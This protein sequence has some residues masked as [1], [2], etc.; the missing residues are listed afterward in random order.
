MKN[1]SGILVSA[2]SLRIEVSFKIGGHSMRRQ[3]KKKKRKRK[4]KGE[5]K[6]SGPDNLE[7]KKKKKIG[8]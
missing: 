4:E 6:V 2:S 7:K 8:F 5:R 1:N 3:L